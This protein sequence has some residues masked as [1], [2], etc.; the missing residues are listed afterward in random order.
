MRFINIL[1]L[2]ALL[3][4]SKFAL[5]QP[6]NLETVIY[7]YVPQQNGTILL[8][9]DQPTTMRASFTVSRPITGNWPNLPIKAQISL[10]VLSPLVSNSLIDVI[11]V[12]TSDWY[13][14]S[15]QISKVIEKDIVIPAGAVNLANQNT[16]IL[17]RW[18]FYKQ[19]YP[20][21]YNTDGWTDWVDKKYTSMSLNLGQIPPSTFSGS[22]AICTEDIYTITNPYTVSL[23][24]A[25]GIATL[26]S[27]GNNQWKV[28]RTATANGVVKLRSTF[29]GIVY[30]KDIAV[31]TPPPII[32]GTSQINTV[33]EY[34]YV[35]S[36]NSSGTTIEYNLMLGGDVELIP[37]SDTQFKIKV[38]NPNT[39]GSTMIV[40]VRARE[41]SSCGTSSYTIKNINLNGN[42]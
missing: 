42:M 34:D 19:G 24:N 20:S 6:I 18:R 30:D 23:E 10:Y 25:A 3:I 38:V 11:D 22:D 33:G 15:Y 5:A 39:S 40:K 21:P 36:R 14:P 16:S 9:Y 13:G 29:N 27:L 35:V 26:T 41:T 12:S 1:S 7:S 37:V 2:F 17:A 8:N 32:S 4:V 31:G 28:T